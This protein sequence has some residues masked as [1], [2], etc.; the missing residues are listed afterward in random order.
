MEEIL[1]I[2]ERL[3]AEK[4]RVRCA[5]A[6]YEYPKREQLPLEIQKDIMKIITVDIDFS[7]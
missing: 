3:G 1:K 2:A 5:R 7:E 4:E 6:F